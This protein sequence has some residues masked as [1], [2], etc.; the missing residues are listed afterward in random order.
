MNRF[1][2]HNTSAG[3]PSNALIRGATNLVKKNIMPN[4][5][6]WG[7][8]CERAKFYFLGPEL[9]LCSSPLLVC[10][11]DLL[12]LDIDE[13]HAGVVVVELVDGDEVG[14]GVLGV[15]ALGLC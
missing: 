4:K 7:G 3:A 8:V 13:L 2:T 11:L 14:R 15:P 9:W 5:K 10:S 12:G 1:S 6:Y